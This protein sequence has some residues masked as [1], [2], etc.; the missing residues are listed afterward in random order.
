MA[1]KRKEGAQVLGQMVSQTMEWFDSPGAQGTVNECVKFS[2]K[3]I[4]SLLKDDLTEVKAKDK[5]QMLAYVGKTL[6]QV[7]RLVQ[8][9]AGAADSRQ[10]VTLATLLPLLSEEEMAIFDKALA[11][12]TATGDTPKSELH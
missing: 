8:F 5:S 3:L 2:K 7:S 1:D 12:I 10:E 11:R 4:A 6:D 9:G